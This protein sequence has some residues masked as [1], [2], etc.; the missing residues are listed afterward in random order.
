[1]T[2]DNFLT[3]I[4]CGLFCASVTSA[5]A[6]VVFKEDFTG[7]YGEGGGFGEKK[8]SDPENAQYN[9]RLITWSQNVGTRLVEISTLAT[10]DNTG[11][12]D[13]VPISTN[14]AISTNDV[15]QNRQGNLVNG[16][17]IFKYPAGIDAWAEERFEITDAALNGRSGLKEIWIQYDQFIPTNYKNRSVADR[18]GSKAVT[19]YA[20]TYASGH[21]RLIVGNVT[22]PTSLDAYI[23]GDMR[24]DGIYTGFDNQYTGPAS[25][26][27]SKD[28]GKWQRRTLH[29]K[30]PTNS[31]SNDGVIE[32]WIRHGDNVVRKHIDISN[33]GFLDVNEGFFKNGYLLG[34]SNPGFDEPT[35]FLIDN[36]I[37]SESVQ[38]INRGA[39][40]YV[41]P[42]KP[43]TTNN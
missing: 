19:L 26:D 36:F 22:G 17:M 35:H 18:W 25:I 37:L 28:L 2:K 24:H 29:V 23:R 12:L 40:E 8:M 16:A 1:M 31:S 5:N 3:I 43:P 21:P 34:W 39:I 13:N 14:P 41:A 11:G 32:Y 7:F 9:N 27:R 10:T 42:P 6:E 30:L 15:P 38:H 20:N 33:G 4:L